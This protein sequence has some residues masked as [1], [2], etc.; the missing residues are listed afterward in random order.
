MKLIVFTATLFWLTGCATL[1][2]NDTPT[3]VMV[4]AQLKKTKKIVAFQSS[5]SLQKLK[6]GLVASDCGNETKTF[7]NIAPAGPG[8]MVGVSTTAEYVVERGVSPDGSHW[9]VL[10]A[11]STM[12]G[13]PAG[14]K[15]VARTDGG[16]DVSVLAADARKVDRIKETVEAGT[17][18]CHWREFDYP[19][20]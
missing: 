18:F 3:Q 6:D 4:D 15:L 2:G 10:R 13:V 7:S 8:M 11:N 1:Y 5:L 9:V 17:L 20:D 19:Y 16:T 12:A 14:A